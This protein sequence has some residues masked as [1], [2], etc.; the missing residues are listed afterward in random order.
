MMTIGKDSMKKLLLLA[1]LFSI[2][3]TVSFAASAKSKNLTLTDNVQVAGQQ[4]KAGDYK[5]KWDD[6]N[7]DSTTVTI[8]QGNKVVATV[9]A[10]IIREKNTTNATFEVNNTDGANK[11]QRVYLSN[12]VLDFAAASSSGM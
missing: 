11:L 8:S 4:L 6:T 1:S 9:P 3:S 5:L 12:E 10:Q 2:L 7:S